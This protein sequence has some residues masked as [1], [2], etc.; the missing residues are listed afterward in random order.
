MPAG[1]ALAH[2]GGRRLLDRVDGRQRAGERRLD[3]LRGLAPL[4]LEGRADLRALALDA[5]YDACALLVDLARSVARHLGSDL[6]V[7]LL[8]GLVDAPAGARLAPHRA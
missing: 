7:A 1:D 2:R 4:R 3:A 5:G 8:R 6:R